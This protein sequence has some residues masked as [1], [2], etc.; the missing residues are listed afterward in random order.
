LLATPGFSGRCDALIEHRTIDGDQIA[1]IIS[2][3]LGMGK[4][5]L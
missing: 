1:E 4:I 3:A 2:T 5:R